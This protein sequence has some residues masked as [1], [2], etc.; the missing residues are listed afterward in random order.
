METSQPEMNESTL[1]EKK[2]FEAGHNLR[3]VNGARRPF[4]AG[5]FGKGL[6]AGLAIF[7][8]FVFFCDH[9]L[10]HRLGAYGNGSSMPQYQTPDTH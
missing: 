7:G 1:K 4:H 10:G 6:L 5:G 2:D 3:S 9:I 8:I